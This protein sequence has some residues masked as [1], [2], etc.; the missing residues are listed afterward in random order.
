[1]PKD[2]NK[3]RANEKETCQLTMYLLK[4]FDDVLQNHSR[5]IVAVGAIL[6]SWFG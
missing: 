5:K 1:M 2:E 4:V 3:K 6:G